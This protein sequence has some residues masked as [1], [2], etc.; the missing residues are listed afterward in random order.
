MVRLRVTRTP[1]SA[2]KGLP[3][4]CHAHGHGEG[5]GFCSTDGS[6]GGFM[7]RPPNSRG[8]RHQQA[9]YME[10]PL[11]GWLCPTRSCEARRAPTGPV[12]PRERL[13]TGSPPGSGADGALLL[14]Q[15]L[16]GNSV[17]KSSWLKLKVSI[18][19]VI[20]LFIKVVP[21]RCH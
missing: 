7:N 9:P 10:G 18:I 12:W 14:P 3:V 15:G 19:W 16:P 6:P 21:V 20:S 11:P 4:Q 2:V 17:P 1:L 8:H 13:S 5:Q